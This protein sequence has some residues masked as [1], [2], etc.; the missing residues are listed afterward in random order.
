MQINVYFEGNAGLKV[1]F[2]RLFAELRPT[3]R[4]TGSDIKFIAARDGPRDYRTALRTNR[5]AWNILLK[6]SEGPIPA[7]LTTLCKKLGIDPAHAKHVFWMVELMESWFLADPKAV[8]AYYGAKGFALKA[9]GNPDD[10]ETISKST[11]L[12]RLKQAAAK[13]L[14]GPYDKVAHAPALLVGLD[15]I[16]VQKHAPHCKKLFDAVKAKL[17]A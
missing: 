8:A 12:R 17:K 6:D 1:G 14:K 2:E 7:Q 13:C 10:V 4:E 5:S 9:L 15:P 16:L 3:V 11:V